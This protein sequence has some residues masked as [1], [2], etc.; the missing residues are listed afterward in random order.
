MFFWQLFVNATNQGDSH[1]SAWLLHQQTCEESSAKNVLKINFLYFP[2]L[3]GGP[4]REG[5]TPA[6]FLSPKSEAA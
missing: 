6:A 5:S 2:G 1:T 3:A 4:R